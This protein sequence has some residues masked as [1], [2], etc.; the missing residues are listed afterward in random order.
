MVARGYYIPEIATQFFALGIATAM[1]AIAGKRIT[2]NESADAFK[3][4]ATELLPA[5]MIVG[6]A[7]GIVL[8]LG[9]D[10]ATE[11][12]VLNTVLHYA[13]SSFDGFST[14]VS[15]WF[16][17]IFQSVFNFFVTS[18]SGQAALTMP[19]VA[20]LSDLVGVSRQIAVLAFPI[21]GWLN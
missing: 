20:P 12:S 17:L 7:K 8:L 13:G 10:K 4:G 18:G 14:Y 21:R 2:V 19:L 3:Q 9:G 6:M 15:A 16:M 5:A 1:L 11:P